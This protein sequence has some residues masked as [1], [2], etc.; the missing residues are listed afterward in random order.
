MQE[1]LQ[2]DYLEANDQADEI[3]EDQDARANIH[4]ES[5]ACTREINENSSKIKKIQE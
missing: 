2:K 1:Q 5:A 4:S 3:R